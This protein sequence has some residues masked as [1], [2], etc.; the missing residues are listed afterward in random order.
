MVDDDGRT[1]DHG[2]P[3]EPNGSGELITRGLKSFFRGPPIL[4]HS[5]L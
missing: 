4:T 1:P 5:L 2:H 3:C